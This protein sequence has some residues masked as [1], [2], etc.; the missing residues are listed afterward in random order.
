MREWKQEYCWGRMGDCWYRLSWV[1]EKGFGVIEL[2]YYVYDFWNESY[3]V[4]G[5]VG[6]IGNEE[7][8]GICMKKM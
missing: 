5:D 8:I 6:N 7:F 4:K 2:V 1:D 3:E